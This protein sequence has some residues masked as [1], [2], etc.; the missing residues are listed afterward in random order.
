M[1]GAYDDRLLDEW[2]QTREICY[3]IYCLGTDPKNRD[4]K[5]KFMPLRNDGKAQWQRLTPAE[6]IKAAK[7]KWK[8]IDEKRKATKQ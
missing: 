2:K 5:L 3:M 1:I 6:Q 4:N 7:E 8:L